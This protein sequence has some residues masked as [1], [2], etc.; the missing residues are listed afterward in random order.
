LLP[1]LSLRW[2]TIFLPYGVRF[3]GFPLGLSSPFT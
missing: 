1:A 3:A 2:F